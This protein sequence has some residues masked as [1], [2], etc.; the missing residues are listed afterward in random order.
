M[1]RGRPRKNPLPIQLEKASQAPK[2]SYAFSLEHEGHA[3]YGVLLH[4]LD[5]GEI[6]KTERIVSG[7]FARGA[8]VRMSR[9]AYLLVIEGKKPD[10][11]RE[12]RPLPNMGVRT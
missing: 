3:L 2:I 4:T 7:D 6:V 9:A 12:H 10:A 5:G 8:M 1:P 11:L